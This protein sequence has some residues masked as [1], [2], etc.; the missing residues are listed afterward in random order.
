MSSGDIDA[1]LRVTSPDYIGNTHP[2]IAFGTLDGPVGRLVLAVT[3]RGVVACS[4]EDEN[5]VFERVSRE[6]GSFMGPDARRL[7]P[8]RRELDAYFSGRLRAFTITADLR[9]A[10][11][12][13]RTVLQKM[14]A[15]PYGTVTTYR[16]I[17]ERIGRPRA[18][19]AVGNALG[20]NP[21]CV[22]VPCH[23]VVESEAV[24]GGYAGGATAKERLL[25]VEGAG[26]GRPPGTP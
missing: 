4:Y 14:T 12:F 3:H 15:V 26:R 18:L 16:E 13:A 10:T 19:R 24:L 2:D 9:L 5:I 7:D 21:V 22:I 20:S 11:P 8:V 6:V 17:A 23:R 25:R 1:L